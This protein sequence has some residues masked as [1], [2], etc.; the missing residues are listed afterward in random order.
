MLFVIDMQND[1]IDKVKGRN[2][3]KDSERIVEGII[4]KIKESE[5]KRGIYILYFWYFN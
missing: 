2:Y 1:Y 3:V 5:K 4:N